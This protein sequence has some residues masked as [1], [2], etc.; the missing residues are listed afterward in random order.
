[1]SNSQ[2]KLRRNKSSPNS[3][4]PQ[5][6]PSPHK[7]CS[8]HPALRKRSNRTRNL[9]VTGCEDNASALNAEA[10][11]DD[12]L[13]T[14]SPATFLN[15]IFRMVPHLNPVGLAGAHNAFPSKHLASTKGLHRESAWAC[16]KL[17][18]T[19]AGMAGTL[20]DASRTGE[21][22][23]G[24]PGFSTFSLWISKFSH[25]HLNANCAVF[26]SVPRGKSLTAFAERAFSCT[27]PTAE[28][29]VRTTPAFSCTSLGSSCQVHA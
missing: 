13:E 4:T 29:L 3:A 21:N 7:P 12:H 25:F 19:L 23:N 28:G 11:T 14:S 16:P 26:S 8:F 1:M 9:E 22:P 10:H 6:A 27:L 17:F 18:P 2:R 20:R 24:P 15:S 5:R